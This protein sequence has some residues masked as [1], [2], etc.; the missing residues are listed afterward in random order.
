[1]RA[2][3]ALALALVAVA[4][5]S[6]PAPPRTFVVTFAQMAYGPTPPSVRVG[7]T[8]HWV[9]NDIF[10]HSATAKDGSF[11][12]DLA[13]KA[14]AD[15]VIQHAGTVVFYCRYHPGMTGRLSVAG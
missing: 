2:A 1:M 13:P 10:Q 15:T 4:G 8:I 9:N 12:V 6:R 14:Q 3:A 7:D 5:C 11:D